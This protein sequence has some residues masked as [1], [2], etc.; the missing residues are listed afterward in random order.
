MRLIAIL[1]LA[2]LLVSLAGCS[3]ASENDPTENPEQVPGSPPSPPVVNDVTALMLQTPVAQR[4]VGP[5][6]AVMTL[7]EA[8][9]V[10]PFP[11]ETPE[12]LPRGFV[13][14][15]VVSVTLQPPAGGQPEPDTVWRPVGVRS[16]YVPISPTSGDR[17]RFI[18]VEQSLLSGKPMV[19]DGK[20]K[21][22]PIGRRFA[23]VWQTDNVEGHKFI[24]VAWD[25]IAYGTATLITSTEDEEETLEVAWSIH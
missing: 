17:Q 20:K 7:E 11:I 13:A 8:R 25:E 22:V 10:L 15:K 6:P 1:S 4:L 5:G 18:M 2:T 24:L 23:D 16:L 3:A 9:E 14:E 12:Y 19:V 21:V